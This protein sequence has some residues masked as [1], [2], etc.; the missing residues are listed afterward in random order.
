MMCKPLW[1]ADFWVNRSGLPGS[2]GRIIVRV[3]WDT[4]KW[5]ACLLLPSLWTTEVPTGRQQAQRCQASC[6]LW[7]SSVHRRYTPH[8]SGCPLELKWASGQ[9]AYW[10]HLSLW[11]ISSLHITTHC[12]LHV[13]NSDYISWE[14]NCCENGGK[15]S[16]VWFRTC[17]KNTICSSIFIILNMAGPL[18]ALSHQCTIP[19]WSKFKGP[20]PLNILHKSANTWWF[21]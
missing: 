11:S 1:Y 9:K 19:L 12:V 20:E 18:S 2:H 16:F 17:F 5:N 4:L 7:G 6:Q 13:S 21:D 14:F 3:S 15:L 10:S 8:H